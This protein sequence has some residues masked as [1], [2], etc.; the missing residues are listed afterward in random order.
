MVQDLR[1]LKNSI[2]HLS[3]RGPTPFFHSDTS[4]VLENVLVHP[5]EKTHVLFVTVELIRL[6]FLNMLPSTLFKCRTNLLG[7][8]DLEE[9]M[10]RALMLLKQITVKVA[11]LYLLDVL[12][13]K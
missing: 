7:S 10:Y 6:L 12:C 9:P 8:E 3:K 1:I 13:S 5:V 11:L 2:N 4:L